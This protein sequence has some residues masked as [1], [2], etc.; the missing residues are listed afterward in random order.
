[1]IGGICLRAQL[2]PMWEKVSPALGKN[3]DIQ[4]QPENATDQRNLLSGMSTLIYPLSLA[5]PI[6]SPI[7]SIK[8]RNILISSCS[9]RT[10][11]ARKHIFVVSVR[12]LQSLHNFDELMDEASMSCLHP[13]L[14]TG[15]ICLKSPLKTTKTPPNSLSVLPTPS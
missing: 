3:P 1:M 8:S 10:V 15:K 6:P 5:D 12:T 7:E 11:E 4:N 2:R 9:A 14:I 13:F